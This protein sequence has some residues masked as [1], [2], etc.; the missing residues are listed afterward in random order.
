MVVLGISCNVD[1]G[2][3][4]VVVLRLMEN[5]DGTRAHE[6]VMQHHT[7]PGEDHAKKL[8]SVEADLDTVLK[9]QRDA[10]V[11]V[12][13]R[14][15]YSPFKKG[16]TSEDERRLE[17][18]GV[19]L[20]TARRHVDATHALNGKQIGHACGTDKPGIVAKAKGMFGAD[21]TDAGM[22][23]LAALATAKA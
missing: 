9:K 22:A 8:A 19:V 23:A 2:E 4:V 13:R 21:L 16:I 5:E 11:V 14:M 10:A 7:D 1:A 17:L 18:Q 15:D 6:L 3:L 12:V 20:A